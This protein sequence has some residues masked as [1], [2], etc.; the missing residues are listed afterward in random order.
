MAGRLVDATQ[1]TSVS[2]G[3]ASTRRA[4]ASSRG[5]VKIG[6]ANIGAPQLGIDSGKLLEQEGLLLL[7]GKRFVKGRGDLRGHFRYG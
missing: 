7:F 2:A 6:V 3:K 5:T 1:R 4:S